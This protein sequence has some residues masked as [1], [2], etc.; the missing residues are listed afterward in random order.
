VGGHIGGAKVALAC[1]FVEAAGL[2]L[3]CLA[4]PFVNG[5]A[6]KLGRVTFAAD[7]D[8]IW[9][10]EAH[11]NDDHKVRTEVAITAAG[12]AAPRLGS[13]GNRWLLWASLTV[14]LFAVASLVDVWRRQ[15][16]S[17]AL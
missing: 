5:R 4:L 14:N 17:A 2:T 8:G 11:D 16:R 15:R 9:R 10:V 13:S 12:A 6:D 3:I 7:R 1:V